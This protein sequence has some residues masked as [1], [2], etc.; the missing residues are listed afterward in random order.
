MEVLGRFVHESINWLDRAEREA[1]EGIVND[2]RFTKGVRNVGYW[3]FAA[4]GMLIL[5]LCPQVMSLL[6]LFDKTVCR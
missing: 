4:H 5:L 1:N 2:D 6:R 3:L